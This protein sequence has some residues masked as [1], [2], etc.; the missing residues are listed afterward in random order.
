VNAEAPLQKDSQPRGAQPDEPRGHLC[1]GK[2]AGSDAAGP[3]EYLEV[4][5]GGVHETQAGPVEQRAQAADVDRQRIDLDDVVAGRKLEQGELCVVGPLPVELGVE[6]VGG[7][8][9]GRLDEGVELALV[10][11]PAEA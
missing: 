6:C 2:P 8:A 9:A 1:V 5:T 10:G 4:L 11:D 7:R 3:L